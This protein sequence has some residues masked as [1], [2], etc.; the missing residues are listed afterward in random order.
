MMSQERESFHQLPLHP[1]SAMVCICCPTKRA[2]G[3]V[4][5]AM[6]APVGDLTT[7]Q[8]SNDG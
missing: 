4:L 8:A 7:A 3:A 5:P 6:L 1:I 2:G